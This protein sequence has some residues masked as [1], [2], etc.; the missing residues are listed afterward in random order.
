VTFIRHFNQV[1]TY[2]LHRTYFCTCPH[3]KSDRPVYIIY[4]KR[5]SSQCQMRGLVATLRLLVRGSTDC[6]RMTVANRNV[7]ARSS[8]DDTSFLKINGYSPRVFFSLLPAFFNVN[9]FIHMAKYYKCS[10]VKSFT[11][12]RLNIDSFLSL[13]IVSFF[14]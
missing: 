11:G 2:T 5:N 1:F 7:Q 8:R 4:R 12:Q 6:H 14:L 10:L 3:A 9:F 13:Y